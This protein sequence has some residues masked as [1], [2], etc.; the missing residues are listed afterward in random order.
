MFLPYGRHTIEDDDVTAVAAALRDDFLTTGPK[1]A[2]FERAFATATGARHAVACSSGT[3]A[4][5]LAVL[6]Q[7]IGSDDAAIVPTVT[8]VATANVVRMVGAEV[9][10]ADV[11]PNTGLIT[12]ETLQAAISR[13]NG[14][15]LRPR[16]ALPV[17]LGGQICDMPRLATVAYAHGMTLI[18]D[19]CHALGIDGIGATAHSALACFSTHPVKTIATGEGGVVVT[20][21][22]ALAS[23]M[24]HLRSHGICHDPAQYRNRALAFEGAEVN[25][26]YYEMTEVGWNYR[27]PDVLCA[28][29]ISQ[30]RKLARFYGRRA[31][32]AALYDA[33]LA[34]LAP[35]LKPVPH[36]GPHGWHLYAVLID[37]VALGMTRG[38]FMKLLR[39]AGIGSQVHYIPVHRQ[40]YYL[41]RY[42][43]QV[44]PGADAYYARCLSLPM[45][46]AMSH[47]DVHRVVDALAQIVGRRN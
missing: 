33:G 29:G 41:E 20:A 25:P 38:W 30:L 17:H 4:L 40:L 8:F 12:A 16:L 37:F 11:D 1:V 6:T 5:H 2:E 24:R 9:V 26:W 44:L 47:S 21:D 36:A 46:P 43:E 42:G 34:P 14:K 35:V 31:E 15:G 18:E 10:F 27:I 23:R 7:D 3:A 19:A 39:D 45:F 22:S 32:I 13:V 28:L